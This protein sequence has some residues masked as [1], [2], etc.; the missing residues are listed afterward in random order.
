VDFH[1]SPPLNCE[2]LAGQRFLSLI[3]L[4]IHFFFFVLRVGFALSLTYWSGISSPRF[5]T[6]PLSGLSGRFKNLYSTYFSLVRWRGPSGRLSVR[7]RSNLCPLIHTYR[8]SC[9]RGVS[10][11]TRFLFSFFAR[12]KSFNYPSPPAFFL[13]VSFPLPLLLT[14]RITLPRALQFN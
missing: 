2:T 8:S 9:K 10:V 4:V 7:W 3:P 14:A 13:Y 11:W 1:Y 6:C 5:V 12:G